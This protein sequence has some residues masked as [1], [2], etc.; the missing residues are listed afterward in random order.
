M[1]RRIGPVLATFPSNGSTNQSVAFPAEIFNPRPESMCQA[2]GAFF[3]ESL[4]GT[5]DSAGSSAAPRVVRHIAN[6]PQQNNG[7]ECTA[8]LLVSSR[9][10][11]RFLP[12]LGPENLSHR[13]QTIRQTQILPMILGI[14]LR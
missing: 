5:P 4:P 10:M 14:K 8:Y 6:N 3:Q 1:K 13:Q 11:E 2:E 12:Q 9:F 7:V